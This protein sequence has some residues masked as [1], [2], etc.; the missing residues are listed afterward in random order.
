MTQAIFPHSHRIMQNAGFLY[1]HRVPLRDYG[2]VG[3]REEKKRL[4]SN[5]HYR[6]FKWHLNTQKINIFISKPHWN[7]PMSFLYESLAKDILFRYIVKNFPKV[8][9]L[10][11]HY[12]KRAIENHS[13]PLWSFWKLQWVFFW[14]HMSSISRKF[15]S[16][17]PTVRQRFR[18]RLKRI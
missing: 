7:H 10:H 3:A 11:C 2:S 12:K 6:L 17:F 15:E 16:V 1:R 18:I 4:C 5:K 14:V 13:L 8:S 9:V